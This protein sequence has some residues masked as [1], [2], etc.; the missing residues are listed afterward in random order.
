MNVEL[1]EWRYVDS[2]R[3]SSRRKGQDNLVEDKSKNRS[4]EDDDEE[5]DEFEK[6]HEEE[7]DEFQ[8]MF[9]KNLLKELDTEFNQIGRRRRRDTNEEEK[10]IV[11]KKKEDEKLE[12][13]FDKEFE[14][15]K[16][17]DD[18]MEE[19]ILA[20]IDH[21]FELEE[22][23]SK[24]HYEIVDKKRE[25]RS[26]LNRFIGRRKSDSSSKKNQAKHQK[27][28]LIS[29]ENIR[30]I[31]GNDNQANSR[32]LDDGSYAVYKLKICAQHI[33]NFDSEMTIIEVGLLTGFE[34]DKEDLQAR[35]Y[36]PKGNQSHT[37]TQLSKVEFT[38]RS[39][40]LYLDSVPFGRP[41]CYTLKLFQISQG[42]Y[43]FV[44]LLI[45]AN[46]YSFDLF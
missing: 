46:N 41:D 20:K 29:D 31:S 24:F 25:K 33:P 23:N 12:K 38:G 37:F 43:Y 35:V 10:E 40:I 11:S 42:N 44:S 32:A 18:E 34:I 3:K 15:L 21:H 17:K 16:A 28:S 9:D 19:L 1:L 14:E 26:I 6:E 7:L 22:D 30:I 2:K 27:A 13:N 39:V 4:D 5:E 36:D 45:F 8:K